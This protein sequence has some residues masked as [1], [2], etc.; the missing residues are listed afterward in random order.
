MSRS[1]LLETQGF[2]QLAEARDG[3]YLYN[4]N[5]IYVGGAIEKYGEYSALEMHTLKQLCSPGDIVIEIGANIGTHTV[6]LARHVGNQGRIL[7][8]EPQRLV[9]QTLCA[10]V[11]LNSL[12]NVDCY[13]AAVGD[14]EGAI[15]VP[16][17]DPNLQTNL[18]GISLVNAQQGV[19]VECLTLNRFMDLP[20]V[21][22]IKIDVEGM[23]T[24]VITGGLQLL[25]K[26][27]PFL[28]VEN[29]RLDRS[30]TLMKLIS[31]LGYRMYWDMP[32]LFNPDNY[33]AEQENLYP[34][35]VSVNMIC[36]HRDANINIEGYEEITDFT[37]HPMH[38]AAAQK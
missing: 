20:R 18:G 25:Q 35:V 37:S 8:I 24:E 3:Y 11:A 27:K 31:G 16:E 34:T 14:K 10:N 7:A 1:R 12:Q 6:S 29:D 17:P 38:T 13:W 5:D 22:M 15:T 36:I 2:N 9:F 26:F 23:E 21:K 4:Q 32:F 33:Y 19:Q 28:Y 30:E